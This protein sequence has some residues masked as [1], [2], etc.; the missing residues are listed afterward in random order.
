MKHKLISLFVL[1]FIIFSCK[2]E[3]KESNSISEPQKSNANTTESDNIKSDSAAVNS[4]S[5]NLAENKKLLLDF[6]LKNDKKPQYFLINNNKDTTI[7]CAE[8]TKITISA[9]SFIVSKTQKEVSGQIKISVKEYYSISDILLGRLST[10]SNGKLLETGGMLD[11]NAVSGLEKC[12]LKK[13][14]SI[15]IEMPKKKEKERMQLFNGKRTN[16]QVNWQLAEVSINLNKVYSK[17]DEMPVY[18]GGN[19]VL[20]KTLGNNIILPDEII[21]GRVTSTFVVDKEGN[22]TNIKIIK[23]LS[24]EVDEA[25]VKAFKKLSKFI[26]GKV[27]GIPVNVQYSLPVNIH[28]DEDGNNG[29]LSSTSNS[30][31]SGNYEVKKTKAEEFGSYL[32]KSAKLGFINCDRFLDYDESSKIDYVINFKNDSNTSVSIIFHSIKSV[33]TGYSNGD[34][35]SFNNIPSGEKITIFAIKY[36]DNKPYLATQETGTSQQK[37]N[38]L[39]FE[40]VTP[41]KLKQEIKKLDQLN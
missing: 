27:N 17:V 30:S 34:N 26:P 28:S 1:V 24:K 15:E 14:K 29:Y 20:Y 11:I 13:G 38:N 37:L 19:Q 40:E 7:V 35:V 41:E 36:V 6:Y 16:D 25:V 33:M 32:F 39:A 3:T 12:D 10:T 4:S 9:N 31:G 21:S 18:P 2:N 23:G 5:N 8:K 22:V